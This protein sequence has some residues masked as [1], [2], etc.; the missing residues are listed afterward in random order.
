MVTFDSANSH[1]EYMDVVRYWSPT[2]QSYAGGD[3][4]VTLLCQGWAIAET[5][6]HEEYWHAGSR[7]V[8]IYHME[9]S[10]GEAIMNVPVFANP[11]VRRMVASTLFQLRP[12][13]ETTEVREQR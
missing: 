2:S 1:F 4:L 10:R 13:A 11:Y 3:A 9:L 6:F 8:T 7:P 5:V 12:L